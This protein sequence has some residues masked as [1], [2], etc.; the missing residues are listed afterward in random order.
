MVF[1]IVSISQGQKI[2]KYVILNILLSLTGANALSWFPCQDGKDRLPILDAVHPWHIQD[3]G[4]T[5]LNGI[6]DPVPPPL[7]PLKI[8]R[9]RNQAAPLQHTVAEQWLVDSGLTSGVY[10][11]FPI[12]QCVSLTS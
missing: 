11:L 5:L 2:C 3:R 9:D 4:I 10:D 1:Y 8:V 6:F 7:F 12:R